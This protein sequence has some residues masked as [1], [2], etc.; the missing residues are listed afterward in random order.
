[1][2]QTLTEECKVPRIIITTQPLT[3]DMIPLLLNI[4]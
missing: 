1:M 2:H 3:E 4:D